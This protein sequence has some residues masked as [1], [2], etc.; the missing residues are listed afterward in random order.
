MI[1]IVQFFFTQALDLRDERLKDARSLVLY[2]LEAALAEAQKPVAIDLM[3]DLG[4]SPDRRRLAPLR[5]GQ[6][7]GLQLLPD[8]DVRQV[9]FG[10]PALWRTDGAALFVAQTLDHLLLLLAREVEQ[11][12]DVRLPKR[13]C[14]RANALFH[15]D[16]VVEQPIAT[17]PRRQSVLNQHRHLRRH[18]LITR[19]CAFLHQFH[20]IFSPILFRHDWRV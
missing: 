10:G 5:G 1:R 19:G 16:G 20:P 6:L 4:I 15:R 17:P 9:V 12:E 14:H 8:Q 7:L 11:R 13:V 18:S 3:H 2:L